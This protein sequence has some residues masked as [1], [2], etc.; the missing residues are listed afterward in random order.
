MRKTGGAH[1]RL[2]CRRLKVGARERQSPGGTRIPAATGLSFLVPLTS[3]TGCSAG[4]IFIP[5]TLTAGRRL[6]REM[7]VAILT[8][9]GPRSAD[10]LDRYAAEQRDIATFCDKAACASSQPR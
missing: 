3:R 4:P 8:E 7:P 1:T 5:S 2:K 6:P 10:G 9:P